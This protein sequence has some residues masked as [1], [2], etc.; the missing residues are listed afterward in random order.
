MKSAQKEAGSKKHVE[1]V[2]DS[3]F[4]AVIQSVFNRKFT[5]KSEVKVSLN[6]EHR[7]TSKMTVT[8]DM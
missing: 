8:S 6:K 7:K 3:V 2:H 1:Q 5:D 4:K